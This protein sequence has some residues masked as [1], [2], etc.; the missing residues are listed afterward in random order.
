VQTQREMVMLRGGRR[1][2]TSTST[3]KH[4]HFRS[5]EALISHIPLSHLAIVVGRGFLCSEPDRGP[6]RRHRRLG[7]AE[8][9]LQPL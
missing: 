7:V 9:R 5:C 2:K 1:R 4:Y 8:A 6:V 3:S